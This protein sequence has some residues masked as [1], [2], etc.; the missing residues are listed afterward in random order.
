MGRGGEGREGVRCR[1]GGHG[2]LS[3]CF[4]EPF[5]DDD[6][7][8]QGDDHESQW[9]IHMGSGRSVAFSWRFGEFQTYAEASW[10]LQKITE[11][12]GM[13]A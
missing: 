6:H 9:P 11:K 10:V 8:S 1:L 5:E 7:E 4:P 2:S 3:P 13:S 12:S